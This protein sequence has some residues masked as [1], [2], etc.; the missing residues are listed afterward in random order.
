MDE[1]DVM[2]APRVY[3]EL[4]YLKFPDRR[5]R[6]AQDTCRDPPQTVVVVPFG[7]PDIRQF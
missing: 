3:R 4:M 7:Q 5:S 6:D 2:L 1:T